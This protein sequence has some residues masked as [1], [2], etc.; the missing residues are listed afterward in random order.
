MQNFPLPS[1]RGWAASALVVATLASAATVYW[2]KSRPS[3]VE[4][5]TA[6]CPEGY[7]FLH[8]F[9][10]AQRAN[11]A[12][13]EERK[14][15]LTAQLGDAPLCTD[16]LLLKRLAKNNAKRFAPPGSGKGLPPRALRA[17]VDAK[18]EMKAL[19]KVVANAEGEW[20]AY[21]VGNQIGK[22][23]FP[24]GARDGIPKVAGR[25]DRFAYDPVG[26]RLFASV[27][28]GG[29]WMSE[30]VNGSIGTL[31]DHWTSI[32]DGLPTQVNSAVAWTAAGGGRVI[33]LTGEHTQGGNSYVGLGVYWSDD[34]GETWNHA[35]GVPD[36][37]LAFALAVDESRPD[38]VYA[39]TGKGLFRS[40]DAGETFTNVALP[41]SEQCAGVE[42]LGPC[43]FANF[44]TDVVV[45]APGGSTDIR[46]SDDGCP[47][48]AAVG[49]R[50]GA[51]P[52]VDG[53]PQSPGN[54]LYRSET[55][56]PGSFRRVGAA[57]VNPQLPLGFAPNARIGRI[58]LGNAVGAN[59]DHDIVYAIVEDAVLFNGGFPLLDFQA[60]NVGITDLCRTVGTLD[61][62][63]T[64]LCSQVLAQVP[65]PTTFNGLYA[66]RDFGDTWVRLTDDANLIANGIQAGSSLAP[67]TAL[68]FGPGIQSWYNLFV[69]P[70]PSS[71]ILGE[72]IRVVFGLEE[73]WKNRVNAPLIGVAEN[74]PVGLDVI[75]TY[76]AGETC[77]F[78]IG[79]LGDPGTPVCPN[80]DG[81]ING[82][83]THPDQHDA[84][85]IEDPDQ[86]GVWLF[87]GNDGGVY[88]QYS[89]DPVT[90]DFANN[91][92]GEGANDGFYTLMNYGIDVAKDGTVYYGLQDNASGKIDP[93]TREQIRIFV[94]DGMWTAVDPDNS[95]IAYYQTPGLAMVRTRDGG[96][97][98]SSMGPGAAAGARQ[99]QSPFV[100]DPLDANHIVAV[101]SA[102]AVT[103]NASTATASSW[104]TVFQLGNNPENGAPNIVR[105]RSL[106]VQGEAIYVGFC[107]PCNLVGS[108]RQFRSGIATNVGGSEPPQKGS[109]AGW[110]F[111]AAQGLPNRNIYNIE[112]DPEDPRTVYVVLGGYS[113]ARW[114]GPGQYLD[115]NPNLGE[116]SVYKSTDAGETF[117]NI[118][119]N[120]PELIA[121][122]V[123]RRGNQL[124]IGTDIGVF[125][126]S[127][128]DGQEWAPLGNL[129]NVPVNQLVLQPGNDRQL[130]AA[131]FGRGV[132]K[133]VFPESGNPVV[134]PVNPVGPGG[135]GIGGDN[136][137]LRDGSGA[138]G[139]GLLPLVGLLW[140]RRRR[141]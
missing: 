83:T 59:H 56:Q 29:V 129:P 100:M 44:V 41:V 95:D 94:G 110:R 115:T 39:A 15:E 105:A 106:D 131:T 7:D 62:A 134:N 60:D 4:T 31:G 123:V 120:L 70:D 92:W 20:V 75:G 74:T 139:L 135:P 9:E 98:N 37:A 121:T 5:A 141:G 54:G 3:A 32:G 118:S 90:D 28:N 35:A 12:L 26:R 109:P 69:K 71:A 57:A 14:A 85:F 46:C 34:L 96:R 77:L 42:T 132:Q 65:R 76:F 122:A 93:V 114:A 125:I 36:E 10:V 116:G 102:V 112:I 17:A 103:T 53:T 24:D 107:G 55:G 30:A 18:A 48:L 80:Y 49:Y 119:G 126:S 113:S 6:L 1:R 21:G 61:P 79:N 130:F 128:L 87:I 50:A 91:R 104:T 72:P 40:E 13:T 89:A 45:K 138:W 101:G 16:R 124:V 58:E 66:S 117:V 25:V 111:A 38:I 97:S 88:K 33:V 133:Y 63:V 78:L 67:V 64:A 136:N 81:L 11:L 2:L 84:F 23:E 68:G 47:V 127:D 86:G 52:Y 108:D 73:V 19:Q 137:G 27:G 140:L 82:T 8:P 43:S 99:F 22:E 51:A